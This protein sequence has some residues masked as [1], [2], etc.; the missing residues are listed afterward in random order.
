MKSRQNPLGKCPQ[1]IRHFSVAGYS[2]PLEI[3]T[4]SKVNHTKSSRHRTSIYPK[5]WLESEQ[6]P[7]S[8]KQKLVKET[9]IWVR[10]LVM[11]WE[12]VRHPKHP[13]YS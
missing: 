8:F 12:G 2:L 6:K 1:Q 3:L 5:E 4:K 7:K 11:Q 9:E 13:R 10:G